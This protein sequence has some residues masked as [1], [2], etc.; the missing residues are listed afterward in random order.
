M[1]KEE[2]ANNRFWSAKENGHSSF[3]ATLLS[4]DDYAKKV[5][6]WLGQ[7]DYTMGEDGNFYH[8]DD[9][10]GNNPLNSEEIIKLYEKHDFLEL[11]EKEKE[12]WIVRYPDDKKELAKFRYEEQA[13]EWRDKYSATSEVVSGLDKIIIANFE[14]EI[15]ESERAG[16]NSVRFPHH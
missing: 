7:S 2:V 12:W 16:R 9:E 4:M 10:D 1:T 14:A 8:K 5:L 13:K 15:E 11:V 3:Q 6:D